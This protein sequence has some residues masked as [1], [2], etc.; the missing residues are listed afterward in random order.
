MENNENQ[1]KPSFLG[2]IKF[3]QISSVV[4]L[5]LFI[6]SLMA[7][8]SGTGL[9]GAISKE[10]AQGKI[11]QYANVVTGGAVVDVG[12]LIEDENNLYK[13]PLTVR[14]QTMNGYITKDGKLFFPAAVDLADFFEKVNSLGTQ[15][16]QGAQANSQPST[17]SAPIDA[18]VDDDPSLGKED[19]PV[20]IVEFSD[21][22]CPFCGR[23]EKDTFGKIKE[24]YIDTGKVKLVFRDF[25]LTS[26]H[27]YAQKAAE[28]SECADEQGKFWK[29]HDKLFENQ[30]ALTVD[31]LK[32]YADD[33]NLNNDK[34]EKCL[35]N[36]DMEK[37]VQN[38]IDDGT[39]YS[40][41]GT[42]AFFIN[43]VIL[44]GA[45]PFENFKK[46]IDEELAK[47]EIKE[48]LNKTDTQ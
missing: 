17:P 18:S 48:D 14:G 42:P 38:D 6:V 44:E 9:S 13:V 41:T 43:G 39:K 2:K 16:D 35:D 1:K 46:I 36:G 32:K 30:E 25:P 24:E 33:L 8:F 11:Q 10:E 3:W 28:A 21:F 12:N 23:F 27:P 15:G 7:N 22:Q 31:D 26:I 47:T 4:L 34:F 20:T 29:Y 40:V 5:I 45:Q 37:E 19:A